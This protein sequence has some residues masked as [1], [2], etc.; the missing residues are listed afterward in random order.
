MSVVP[1][2]GT[3]AADK[4]AL[5]IGALVGAAGSLVGLGVRSEDRLDLGAIELAFI[6]GAY[7][8]MAFRE[9]SRAKIALEC[10]ASGL[11][12]GLALAGLKRRSRLALAAQFARSK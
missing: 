1:A 9:Q 4:R 11:F 8:A 7:P 6:A 2:N 10:A 3:L 5:S 12:V